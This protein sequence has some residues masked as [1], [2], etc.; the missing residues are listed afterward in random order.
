MERDQENTWR[1]ETEKEEI[2]KRESEKGLTWL[3]SFIS[4]VYQS[5]C[6]CVCVCMCVHVGTGI[7]GKNQMQSIVKY[8]LDVYTSAKTEAP[9]A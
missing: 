4:T 3:S 5:V 2:C 7:F 8:K 9:M 1:K 6:V